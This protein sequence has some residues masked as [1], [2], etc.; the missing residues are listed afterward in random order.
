MSRM[1][2]GLHCGRIDYQN[3]YK[4]GAAVGTDIFKETI[5]G[6]KL[7]TAVTLMVD[8][9]YSMHKI[10]G[11]VQ[12]L[13]M[14]LADML[15]GKV[16]LEILIQSCY[17]HDSNVKRKQ[18]EAKWPRVKRWGDVGYNRLQPVQIRVVK[19]FGE[20]HS[21]VKN[22]YSFRPT[23]NAVENEALRV[24]AQRIE[25]RRSKRKIIFSITDG[26]PCS[27]TDDNCTSALREDLKEVVKKITLNTNI[28]LVGLG[29][30]RGGRSCVSKYYPDYVDCADM[31]DLASKGM[32]K[33]SKLLRKGRKVA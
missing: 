10:W 4:L 1:S 6:Q 3:I 22:F 20:P 14:S 15:K 29:I 13:V 26:E 33:L 8:G 28:E 2:R 25:L 21:K 31:K 12:E 17:W 24:A 11:K 19:S 27:D 30:G 5:Q 32:K 23:C 16:E 18:V 9:S 7:D